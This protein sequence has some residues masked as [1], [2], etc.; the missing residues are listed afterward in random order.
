MGGVRQRYKNKTAALNAVSEPAKGTKGGKGGAGEVDAVGGADVRPKRLFAR[1]AEAASGG[2]TLSP[3]DALEAMHW[4]RQAI[5]VVAGLVFGAAG[6]EGVSPISVFL[7]C[8]FVIP[9]AYFQGKLQVDEDQVAR[10][11]SL[12]TEGLMSSIA[13]FFLF[14]ILTFTTFS[15]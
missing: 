10:V 5:G 15:R 2:D 1:V 3:E 8:C 14:W 9:N 12:K 6:L 4:I 11:G 13:L 7:L